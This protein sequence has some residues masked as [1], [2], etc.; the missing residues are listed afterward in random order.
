MTRIVLMVHASAE[1]YGSDRVLKEI[2]CC[3]Q[4]SGRYKPVVVLPEEGTLLHA[5]RACGVEAHAAPV[6]KIS[7]AALSFTGALRIPS[8]LTQ[9][10]RALD[11]VV[12]G[13]EVALVHSNTLAVL[14][15]AVWA[16]TRR[17]PHV[18]HLHEILIRPRLMRAAL[19]QLATAFSDALICNSFST[20]RWLLAV[21]PRAR[22]RSVVAMNGL[23]TAPRA[24]DSAV[25]AFRATVNASPDDVVATLIGRFNH[26]KGQPLLVRALARLRDAG[27]ASRL[28]VVM[29]GDV[30]AGH[31]DYRSECV[32][33][34]ASLG[35]QSRV[36]I[37]PFTPDV[38]PIWLGSD[39][40]VVP[41]TEPESFGLVAIEAMACGLPVVAAAHG[42][43]LDIV[44]P[45]VTGLLVPP[46]REAELADALALLAGDR[47]MRRRM[48]EAG[49]AC[50][51]QVF[52][53]ESQ[54]KTLLKV[55]DNMAFR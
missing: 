13:R 2:A 17:R 30:Y 18:W 39:I 34:V 1:L 19:P 32:Q 29:A 21:A 7:R 22:G 27:R 9:A 43:L 14:G 4:Q 44:Q 3:L 38:G 15:G 5:L 53:L 47:A 12:A 49:R 40:A 37:L 16:R 33:L 23:A 10:V 11:R 52:T 25:A 8:M 31:R 41:S 51:Q 54:M 36:S 48:G 46:C 45:E 55:Y 6:A 35:L 24:D 26:L 28:R 20:E 50:Q 42:G